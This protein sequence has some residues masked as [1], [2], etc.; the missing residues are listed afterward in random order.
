MTLVWLLIWAIGWVIVY[1]VEIIMSEDYP[2]CWNDSN[3]YLAMSV[4]CFSWFV[5]ALFVIMAFTALICIGIGFVLKHT[6]SPVFDKFEK[7]IYHLGKEKE[8]E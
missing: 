7:F 1:S 4:A 5:I 6:V 3:R 2:H 8:S